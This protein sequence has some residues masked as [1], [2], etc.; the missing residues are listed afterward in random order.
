[1][2]ILFDRAANPFCKFCRGHYREYYC[3]IIFKFRPVVQEE[4]FLFLALAS[5][6]FNEAKPMVEGIIG[7]IHVIS[8]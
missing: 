4:I 1:M 3:E 2:A 6:L 5:I 8:F 7:N